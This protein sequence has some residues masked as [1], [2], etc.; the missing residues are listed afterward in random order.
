MGVTHEE[1]AAPN[2]DGATEPVTQVVV[3]SV[4]DACANCGAP[5][6]SD[7]RYCVNCGQRRGKSRFAVA[8]ESQP[9]A[10]PLT[11]V[12]AT[13]SEPPPPRRP[14]YG[15]TVIAG[16]ATLLI[17]LGV[18]VEIGRLSNQHN[19][20]AAA[21]STPVITINGNG[22]SAGSNTTAVGNTGSTGSAGS[23]AGHKAHKAAPAPK[24]EVIRAQQAA[25]AAKPTTKAVQKAS[26]AASSVLGG[27]GAQGNATETTGSQCAAGTPGCQNGKFTGGF[28]S[29]GQ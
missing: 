19:G 10:P 21:A 28:F 7:Q 23:T 12:A 2:Q 18:G 25:K 17:A 14:S 27:S 4:S 1:G 8:N 16:V 22:A 20:G 29:G 6:A 3:G 13:T 9:P 24:T 26:N 5:L 11:R 15:A